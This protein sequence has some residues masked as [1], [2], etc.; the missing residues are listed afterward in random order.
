MLPSQQPDPLSVLVTGATTRIGKFLLPRLAERGFKVYA[1]S[2]MPPARAEQPAI[3]WFKSD[4]DKG[5]IPAVAVDC[6]F[7]LAPI[8]LLPPLISA[9]LA[10]LS[11]GNNPSQM[12]VNNLR[13]IIAFSSTSRFSKINSANP[14]ER[15]LAH[16]LAQAENELC[17]LCHSL[18]IAWTVLR[19]TLIYGGGPNKNI[20]VITNFIRRFGFFPLIGEAKGLRQP[21]HADD[22]AAAS[23]AVLENSA[24][25]NRAYNLSGGETLSYREMVKRI[26]LKLGKKPRFLRIP[27]PLFQAAI[28]IVSLLPQYRFLSGEMAQ[29]M[30]QDLYFD[31]EDALRDFGY[32]PRIFD[33]PT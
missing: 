7:H 3:T 33:P 29:R 2:R 15:D 30:N 21:V 8:T 26:F 22:L 23:L 32:E 13:R 4:I 1:L 12:T 16:R 18:G 28:S 5:E 19:P 6:I 31:H 25:F 14:L 17:S 24:T 27:L 10:N 11:A 9:M 20:T